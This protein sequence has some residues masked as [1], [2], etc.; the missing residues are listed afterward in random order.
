MWNR[1]VGDGA[2]RVR[3]GFKILTPNTFWWSSSSER[4]E[5]R[6]ETTRLIQ[7]RCLHGTR[8][9]RLLVSRP[10]VYERKLKLHLPESH[11]NAFHESDA[12]H[13]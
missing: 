4:S 1:P 11:G 7:N 5:E 9:S 6:I 8:W 10:S 3:A 12:D 2:M 13:Q